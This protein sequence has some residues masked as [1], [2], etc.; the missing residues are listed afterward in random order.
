MKNQLAHDL[1]EN[2]LVPD[3]LIRHGIR[4]LL[5][6]R[7]A[8][9]HADD[10]E[11]VA[12]DQEAFIAH[13]REAGIAEVP[14]KAN[15][16]HYEVPAAF[17]KEV[18]G[19]RF[20]YSCGY[21]PEGVENLNDAESAALS[22][23]CARARLGDGMKILELGCGWGSLT[24]W[25]AM[26]YPSSQITAVSNSSSQGDFIRERA[27]QAGLENV[28]VITADMNNFDTQDEFDRV[29]SVEMFEHM[30]NWPE[31]YRRISQW[32]KP[33]GEFFMHVFVHRSTPYLFEDK[34]ASDWMSRH[35]FSGGMMPS[36]D[37][38]LFFQDHLK[39]EQ[40][41]QWDGRHYEKTA[42]AWLANMDANR[43]DIWPVLEATYG[44]DFA[45]VW[46]MRW[47]MFFMACAELFG[48]NQGQEWFVS[49]YRFSNRRR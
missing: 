5:R 49:H 36:T 45:R 23:T 28:H 37:L 25:M 4:H 41:W 19:S 33:N 32:L 31:L 34:E 48:F 18:L 13:M 15:E 22:A 46:W 38:P 2:G 3:K 24:L 26:N 47:R 42:N 29:V 30:R 6:Q 44:K 11:R 43:K 17:Y 8:D 40:R 10:N 16:Q 14:Q 35:F 20:K 39:L 12:R 9:I 21:W 7:L 1:T 27:R